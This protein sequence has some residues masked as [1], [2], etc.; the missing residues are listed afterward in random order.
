MFRLTDTDFEGSILDC[1]G[2]PSSFS[3]ELFEREIMVRSIDPLYRYS[4]GEIVH[5]FMATLDDVIC[6]VDRTPANW[7]WT[8]HG[9]SSGLRLNRIHEMRRFLADYN[10]Q[11]R[12]GR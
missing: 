10:S 11:A 1:G 4:G 8:Y 9:S 12:S 3:A 6:Q 7:V 2:G 5:R